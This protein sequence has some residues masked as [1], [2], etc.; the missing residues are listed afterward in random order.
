MHKRYYPIIAFILQAKQTFNP[1]F[2]PLTKKNF[3]R[4]SHFMIDTTPFI[5][6]A[7]GWCS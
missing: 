7:V 4:K 5:D 3:N 6:N 1:E 2:F